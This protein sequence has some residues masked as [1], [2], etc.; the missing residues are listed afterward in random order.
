VDG[1]D[2]S[3]LN[4][5]DFFAALSSRDKA[6]IATNC[7]ELKV[8]SGFLLIQQG[9]VGKDVYLLEEGAVRVYRGQP[10]SPR[11]LAVLEAPAILGEMA[12]LDKERIRTSSVTALTDLRLLSVPIATFLVFVGVYPTLKERLRRLVDSRR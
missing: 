9:Q 12:L 1:V 11:V 3:R 8:P 6:F 10:E 4:S 7:K 5:F 2:V